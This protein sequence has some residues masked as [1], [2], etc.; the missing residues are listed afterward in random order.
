MTTK[1][2]MTIAEARA[3]VV[4]AARRRGETWH[5]AGVLAGINGADYISIATSAM[6]LA[7]RVCPRIGVEYLTLRRSA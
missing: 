5:H 4:V 2:R 6:T 3:R 1:E 7:R